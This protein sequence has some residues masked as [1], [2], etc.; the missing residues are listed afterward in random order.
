MSGD[1]ALLEILRK[2]GVVD[3]HMDSGPTCIKRILVEAW[4]KG[5]PDKDGDVSL[6]NVLKANYTLAR[7]WISKQKKSWKLRDLLCDT[8][9]CECAG[10][11]TRKGMVTCSTD[12]TFCIMITMASNQQT[13]TDSVCFIR[14]QCADQD[15]LKRIRDNGLFPAIALLSTNCTT[16]LRVAE[17]PAW[18]GKDAGAL[19]DHYI[20][21][22]LKVFKHKKGFVNLQHIGVLQIARKPGP[23]TT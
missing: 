21:T 3:R 16:A 10:C 5:H 9:P 6:C 15:T 23:R 18:I 22:D 12:L 20:T 7:D 2:L 13:R 1:R 14:G 4:R 8:P 17:V 11:K 19:T